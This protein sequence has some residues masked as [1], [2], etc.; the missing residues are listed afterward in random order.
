MGCYT[1]W[2]ADREVGRNRSGALVGKRNCDQI[3]AADVKHK[4]II[5]RKTQT[6]R[7]LETI[8]HRLGYST[9]L[10]Y[11]ST[12]RIADI[13]G[14]VGGDCYTGR[15]SEASRPDLNVASAGNL[16]Q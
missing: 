15:P 2:S 12:A 3:P 16:K 10:V 13:A 14:A 7:L 9:D 4:Q 11:S 6:V 5:S 1:N 8:E